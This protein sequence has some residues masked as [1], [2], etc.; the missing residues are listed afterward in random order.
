MSN[1]TILIVDDNPSNL[2]LLELALTAALKLECQIY[3][4]GTHKAAVKLLEAQGVDIALLDVELP[5]GNGLELARQLRHEAPSTLIIMLSALDER[6]VIDKA[7]RA[8][9][10]AYITKPF[11]LRDVLKLFETL[12]VASPKSENGL[13]NS[14]AMWVQYSHQALTSYKCE[15]G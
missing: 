15:D 13:S 11:N 12:Q 2:K 14:H 6:D 4:A 3:Q 7:C 1:K 10:D 8:G 5:D 9:A